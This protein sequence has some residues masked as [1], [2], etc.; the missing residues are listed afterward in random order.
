MGKVNVSDLPI[1][2]QEIWKDMIMPVDTNIKLEDVILSDDNKEKIKAFIKE[3]KYREKLNEHGLKMMNRLLF[4][5][6]SGTGKT[7]LSKALSNHLG[8]TML[9]VD[10]AKALTEG[11]VSQNVANI[12]ELANYL[13]ECIIMLDECDSIAWN[14]DSG[15]AESGVIR[16]ATNSIFQ[17][18][19]QMRNDVIVVAATNMLHRLDAAFERRFNLKL[20]FTRPD[21]DLDI[22]IRKFMFP[23]FLLVDDIQKDKKDIIK[24][25]AKQNVKLSYYEI[26]VVVER[27]MKDAVLNDTLEVKTS[28]I[29]Q[30]IADNMNFKV[31]F[32]THDDPDEIFKNSQSYDPSIRRS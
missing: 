11:N 7:F 12:F 21:L 27:A 22:V 23:K 17:Y 25:R 1:H 28:N 2:L 9:Y 18:M 24:K 20:M 30:M 14:R 15:T 29:Y 32:G 8:Y 26:Q 3:V 6:A 13:G 31:R 10:I 4:Y 16:R 5:G 19:D